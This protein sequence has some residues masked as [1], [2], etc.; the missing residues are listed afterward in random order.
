MKKIEVTAEKLKLSS[1]RRSCFKNYID[2]AYSSQ[3]NCYED[4]TK[5][6]TERKI[7]DCTELD[8]LLKVACE[9]SNYLSILI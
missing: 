5:L 6:K 7:K 9:K 4:N 3:K 2:S 1:N 8:Y